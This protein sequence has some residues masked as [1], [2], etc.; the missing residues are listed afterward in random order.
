M[1]EFLVTIILIIIFLIL[2]VITICIYNRLM[3]YKN[4]LISNYSE[5]YILIE[6]KFRIVDSNRLK[7]D[8]EL[9]ELVDK[10]NTLDDEN[11]VIN[12]SLELDRVMNKYKRRV[13]YKDYKD[14]IE[15]INEVKKVYNDNVLRFNNLIKMFPISI[16]SNLFGFDTW[17]YYRND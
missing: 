13:W 4:E 16:I 11:D 14:V 1:F 9:K 6:N 12:I 15:N 7:K 5:L 3:Y 17:L 2:L 8:I 10:F